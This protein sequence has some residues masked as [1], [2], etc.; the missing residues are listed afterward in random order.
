M[1]RRV[2]TL[3]LLAA[4]VQAWGQPVTGSADVSWHEGAVECDAASWEPLQVHAYEPMTYILRQNPCAHFEANV[5]YLLVGGSRALL[6]DTGPIDDPVRMP[7]ARTVLGLLPTNEAGRLP[8]LVV[9][10]HGHSDHRDGDAQFISLPSVEI[11]PRGPD[12]LRGFYGFDDWPD[13]SA[14]LDL[15]GR[16]VHVLPVP[17]HHPDH[18]AF[19]DERTALLFSGDFL[20]PGRLLVDDVAAYRASAS[21]LIG[22]LA[23]RP[24]AHVLG[25]HVELDVDGRLYPR[26]ASHHPDERPLALAGDDLVAL[27]AALG[28]FNGFYARHPHFT[29]SHPLR[30]LMVLAAAA[31]LVLALLAW[32]TRRL[33]R[34]RRHSR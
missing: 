31:L 21:R 11:A 4:S 5:I 16:T 8:L 25:G 29:L 13:G 17:G 6:I 18:L 30:N 20:L 26:G 23:G 1:A 19:Y 12:A 22:W 27:A 14:S 32:G 3:M 34:S 10:S 7:L 24:V 2:A 33:L 28:D 15:G 9:H